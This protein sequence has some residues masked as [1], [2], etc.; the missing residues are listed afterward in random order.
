MH[1]LKIIIHDYSGHPFQVQLSRELATRGHEVTH[2]YSKNF[3]TPRGKLVKSEHDAPTLDIVG[4]SL[5]EAFQ[6][7]TFLKRRNQE[8]E[9]G[10]RVADIIK[11]IKPDIVVSS[12]SPLDAQWHI[13]RA[14]QDIGA[15]FI[16]WLQDIYSEAISRILP[17]KIPVLGHAIGAFYKL[18]EFKMLKSS[19]AIV[20]ITEDFKTILAHENVVADK[21]HVIENW[22]PLDEIVPI[23]PDNDWAKA[24]MAEGEIK[25]VY[26]GTLGLKHNPDLLLNLAENLPNAVVYVFSEGEAANYLKSKAQSKGVSNLKMASWVA[27]EDLSAML[28]GA[29]IFVAMIEK[30]AGQYCVPSKVLSYFCVGRPILAAIPKGNLAQRLIENQEAGLVAEPDNISALIECA[31]KLSTDKALREKM[32]R[33]GTDYAQK[34]FNI[35][36]IADKF[37]TIFKL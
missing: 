19:D 4:V 20:S 16:F 30:E 24:H 28:S 7:N 2:L 27:F 26:S 23:S 35:T 3:Q 37:E 15:Q 32:G 21:I 9:Y 12:N 33:N 25:I 22:A 11:E 6:K 8:I 13:Q 5:K 10:Q 1:K 14:S 34:H 17:S 36:A 29:D 31:K 18:L